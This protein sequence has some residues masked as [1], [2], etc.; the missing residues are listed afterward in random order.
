MDI[1]Q[2]DRDRF[3]L[4]L[5]AV[6]DKALEKLGLGSVRRGGA[7]LSIAWGS[8][9]DEVYSVV[10]DLDAFRALSTDKMVERVIMRIRA[11][12]DDLLSRD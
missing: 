1:S 2:E 6:A 8:L 4:L 9:H 5:T 12:K 3:E 11:W 7:P 10:N